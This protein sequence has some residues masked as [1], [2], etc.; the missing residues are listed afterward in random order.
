[1]FRAEGR[2]TDNPIGPKG[3]ERV[4]KL[5]IAVREDQE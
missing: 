5:R 3:F 2:A 4:I 1:M